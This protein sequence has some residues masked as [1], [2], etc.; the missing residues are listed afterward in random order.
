[1]RQEEEFDRMVVDKEQMVSENELLIQNID[2]KEE[3]IFVLEDQ[4]KNYELM[5]EAVNDLQTNLDQEKDQ[6]SVLLNQVEALKIHITKQEEE[7][8]R[9]DFDKERTVAENE[10]LIRNYRAKRRAYFGVRRSI[11]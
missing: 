9:V 5:K 8:E 3:R 4:M 7:L 1:M 6:R 2:Q 11:E 10:L